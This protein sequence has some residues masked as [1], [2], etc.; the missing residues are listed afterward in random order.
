ML[1]RAAETLTG[2][3]NTVHNR[4]QGLL[5]RHESEASSSTFAASPNER[6]SPNRFVR[7]PP[8]L[9]E[10]ATPSPPQSGKRRRS[11][12]EDSPGRSR[13]SSRNNS[14]AQSL[15]RNYQQ[16][17]KDATQIFVP[18]YDPGNDWNPQPPARAQ[19]EKMGGPYR[20]SKGVKPR[21]TLDQPSVQSGNKGPLSTAQQ[22]LT[23]PIFK[24]FANRRVSQPQQLQIS[25]SKGSNVATPLDVDDDL[26]YE[27]PPT[28]K[29]RLDYSSWG[30]LTADDDLTQAEALPAR[31]SNRRSVSHG[32][33]TGVSERSRQRRKGGGDAFGNNELYEADREAKNWTPKQKYSYTSVKGGL[34]VPPHQAPHSSPRAGHHIASNGTAQSPLDVDADTL[35]SAAEN[36]NTLASGGRRDDARYMPDIKLM[37]GVDEAGE[38]QKRKRRT[39]EQGSASDQNDV[40]NFFESVKHLKPSSVK[41]RPA[42]TAAPRRSIP[43]PQVVYMDQHSQRGTPRSKAAR[44]HQSANMRGNFV[45]DKVQIDDDDSPVE[46]V[47]MHSQPQPRQPVFPSQSQPREHSPDVLGGETTVGSLKSRSASPKKVASAPRSEPVGSAYDSPKARTYNSSLKPTN[48]TR[49]ADQKPAVPKKVNADIWT[50]GE[51]DGDVGRTQ[52]TTLICRGFAMQATGY[53]LVWDHAN[54]KFLLADESGTLVLS[55]WRKEPVQICKFAAAHGF[56]SSPSSTKVILKGSSDWMSSGHILLHFLTLEGKNSTY[57]KFRDEFDVEF[58]DVGADRLDSMFTNL[59]NKEIKGFLKLRD[60]AEARPTQAQADDD[61]I[62]YDTE[63][64]SSAVKQPSRREKLVSKM[65]RETLSEVLQAQE[66][67]QNGAGQPLSRLVGAGSQQF[68]NEPTRRSTRQSKPPPQHREASPELIRWTE[69]HE[70]PKWSKSVVYPQVGTRRVTVDVDDLR[71]LDAGEFLNDN[72]V[73]YALRHIEETMSP[74]HKERVHFFNTFF[75]SSL[76]TKNGKKDFN[77]DAVKKWTKNADLLS[78]PYI[79]VPINLDLHWFVAIIYNL[80]ALR[81]KMIDT[82]DEPSAEDAI[83]LC[84]DGEVLPAKTEEP[85]PKLEQMS[86]SDSAEGRTDDHHAQK[87]GTADGTE[88]AAE[89]TASS[90]P[91]IKGKKGKKKRVVPVRKFSPDQPMIISLDSFGLARPNEL[92]VIKKY[93]IEEAREKRQMAVAMDDLQGVNA[94]GIPQQD[95]FYDCGVYLI[96]YM[97][98]FARDPDRFVKKILGRQIDE[99]DFKEFNTTALRDEIRDT[100]VE[101]G[102]EQDAQYKKDKLARASARKNGQTPQVGKT[103]SGALPSAHAT[104]TRADASAPPPSSQPA[105]DSASAEKLVRQ[106]TPVQQQSPSASRGVSPSSSKVVPS[107]RKSPRKGVPHEGGADENDDELEV[108]A[109]RPLTKSHKG[110]NPQS[111]SSP[112][113]EPDEKHDQEDD[114]EMLDTADPNA[115]DSHG[116]RSAT[117]PKRPAPVH[118]AHLSP[119]SSLEQDNRNSRTRS[120]G[121]ASTISAGVS[122]DMVSRA[123]IAA[124]DKTSEEVQV[125]QDG[126]EGAETDDESGTDESEHFPQRTI[127]VDIGDEGEPDPLGNSAPDEEAFE[128]FPDGTGNN[129]VEIPDSQPDARQSQVGQ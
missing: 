44:E 42:V 61:V 83:D 9:E 35:Q 53:A 11:E 93:V 88:L 75:F 105:R 34:P 89:E 18:K 125:G 77:Y 54:E 21:N 26:E 102:D 91:T 103:P 84:S 30:E 121:L 96:G 40:K 101:Y 74:I 81:R 71:H 97:K 38:A 2:L 115:G 14:S 114:H 47:R 10:V 123:Q 64:P 41:A 116:S 49:A 24:P 15:A 111:R 16:T 62:M 13:K 106:V 113:T 5:Q 128:G 17:P 33:A 1:S 92:R 98:E 6:T 4:V 19:H 8:L 120:P 48:F 94:K 124:Q 39:I 70:M 63:Q 107:P 55:P 52:I 58:V 45:R 90:Q 117:P 119:L 29:S 80:P 32:S 3:K 78:K 67:Q 126:V 31:P 108:D 118:N 69:Q 129:G 50:L 23:K 72:I 68:A 12:E 122:N 86:L 100:L 104:L 110:L 59:G 112:A 7:M 57:E 22:H 109:P 76:T 87:H 28:K 65:K 95:N 27:R 73:N 46:I 25:T 127:V 85:H 43:Q 60:Q 79:V 99:N 82:D 66:I 56:L 20:P 36:P 37:N 51:D